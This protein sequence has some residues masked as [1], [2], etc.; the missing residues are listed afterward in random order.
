MGVAVGSLCPVTYGTDAVRGCWSSWPAAGG[1]VA[2]VAE[3]YL[4]Y[5]SDDLDGILAQAP[6]HHLGPY[7]WFL[8]GSCLCQGVSHSVMVARE[9]AAQPSYSADWQCEGW[10]RVCCFEVGQMKKA[11]LGVVLKAPDE[12]DVLGE[13]S[14][15]TVTLT[16]SWGS[17][18]GYCWACQQE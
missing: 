13:G 16:H 4:S 14:A 12:V 8:P 9:A 2:A 6:L 18:A 17:T 1:D 11:V 3:A 10:K 5:P 7:F 15:A